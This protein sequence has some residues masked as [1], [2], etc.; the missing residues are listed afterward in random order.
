MKTTRFFQVSMLALG[1]SMNS[2]TAS[3]D[4]DTQQPAIVTPQPGA[5]CKQASFRQFDFWI[6]EWA[7]FDAQ[8]RKLGENRIS[9]VNN[10]CTLA[11][12][13]TNSSGG[14]GRSYNAYDSITRQWYQFWSD[15]QGGTLSLSGGLKNGAMVLTGERPSLID[16]KP[17]RQRISWTPLANGNVRQHWETSDDDGA[18][19]QT[20]F[21]GEY[22]RKG[23]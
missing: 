7:V 15:D 23:D 8:G 11:E 9:A 6:G 2:S 13:W 22:R 19:W 21:D 3:G 18:S 12:H 16:G 17:Q 20:S 4:S 10:G 1:A 14:E 5:I